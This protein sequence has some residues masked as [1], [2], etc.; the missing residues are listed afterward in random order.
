M[1]A[2]KNIVDIVVL[3]VII[4]IGIFTSVL[5]NDRS[6]RYLL[7]AAV[8]ILY[9]VDLDKSPLHANPVYAGHRQLLLCDRPELPIDSE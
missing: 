8:K 9:S 7:F 5:F 3:I 6:V 1:S 4:L 2:N